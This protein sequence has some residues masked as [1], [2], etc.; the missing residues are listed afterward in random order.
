MSVQEPRVSQ[1]LASIKCQGCGQTVDFNLLDQ[2]TCKAAPAVPALPAMYQNSNKNISTQQDNSYNKNLPNQYGRQIPRSQNGSFDNSNISPTD[3]GYS[4]STHNSTATN[5]NHNNK[6]V[7]PMPNSNQ[8]PTT[9]STGGDQYRGHKQ[10]D[11]YPAR[12]QTGPFDR[13]QQRSPFEENLRH[14]SD[15]P[16]GLV[17]TLHQ[18]PSQFDKYNNHLHTNNDY[19]HNRKPSYDDRSRSPV[20]YDNGNNNRFPPSPTNQSYDI[21]SDQQNH[22][23]KYSQDRKINNPI[24]QQQPPVPPLPSAMS[25]SGS[26]YDNS[27]SQH[28]FR[29]PSSDQNNYGLTMPGVGMA[30][31]HLRIQIPITI[32]LVGPG[33]L[34]QGN[35]NLKMN[36]A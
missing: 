1:L 32:F 28:N 34:P 4:S 12:K 19:H 30:R 20:P 8:P 31:F 16:Y 9:T 36:G 10:Q 17:K 35:D 23:R 27:R 25:N 26:G 2:H 29:N 3:S 22:A 18:Q 14:N 5:F 33:I 6:Y 21:R 24:Q 15:D 13:D 7:N 11:K